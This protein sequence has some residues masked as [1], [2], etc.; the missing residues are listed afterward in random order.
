MKW[1]A[2][3]VALTL[4]KPGLLKT[5]C[6]WGRGV[7]ETLEINRKYLLNTFVVR[8]CKWCLVTVRERFM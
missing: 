2:V 5:F 6:R 4:G 7:G 8:K 3:N 1:Q